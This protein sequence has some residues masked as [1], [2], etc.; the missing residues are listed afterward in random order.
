MSNNKSEDLEFLIDNW[1][2]IPVAS[3][4]VFM[5]S[6][7]YI[8][9]PWDHWNKVVEKVKT[10]NKDNEKN[11]N[12]IDNKLHDDNKNL[13]INNTEKQE[14]E[15]QQESD[16]KDECIKKTESNVLNND[17]ISDYESDIDAAKSVDWELSDN[18]I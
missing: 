10:N 5:N 13:S 16:N 14:N 2:K 3:T 9:P 15:V 4:E 1:R 12:N 8:L 11:S 17:F 7:P 6:F 18:E